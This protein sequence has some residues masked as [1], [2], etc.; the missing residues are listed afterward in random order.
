LLV[1]RHRTTRMMTTSYVLS[2]DEWNADE[3]CVVFSDKISSRRKK[4]LISLS[5]NLKRDIQGLFKTVEIMEARGDYS[6]L[7]LLHCFRR[8]QQGQLFVA[9]VSEKAKQLIDE[10]RFGTAHTYQYAANSFLK[11]LKNKDIRIDKIN[12]VLIKEYENYLTSEKKSKNTISCYMRALRA[13]WNCAIREK[14]FTVKKSTGNPFSKVF[15]GNAKTC[16]RAISVENIAKLV[17]MKE[18][19]GSYR[20]LNE[21]TGIEEGKEGEEIKEEKKVKKASVN[22][23]SLCLD[24]FLFSF[25]TQGMPFTDMAHLK[26]ENIKDGFIRYKRKKT[27]QEICIEVEGCT[28][29]IIDRYDNKDSDFV[30]PI[31]G[32][33]KDV[34]DE[35]DRWQKTSAALAAYNRNLKKLACLAGIEE[36]LTSYVARHSWATIASQEGIPIATISRGMG[37]ESEKTTRIYI[38]QT[39]HSDVGR[40]NR[41][42]LSR[43][44]LP[45]PPV[46]PPEGT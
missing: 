20:E 27:G 18:V 9:Y 23:L 37:H 7:E 8:W 46:T 4:E 29:E 25:Y 10:K 17:Q 38:D 26:K 6:S 36:I 11:F 34:E 21:V 44:S 1:T 35:Y 45:P 41:Q 24:L 33:L 14:V 16:K 31:L 39:T 32:N 19:T 2:A 43:V 42:I 15:T 30:F 40:A 5:T 12:P 13:A 22:P 28:K 3:Q